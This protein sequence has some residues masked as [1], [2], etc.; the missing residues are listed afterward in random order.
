[1]TRPHD[2]WAEVYDLAYEQEFGA[3]FGYLTEQTL[4]VVGSLVGPG[5]DVVD[6]G[7]GTGR[8][9]T[10]LA[11][12]GHRVVA[13]EPSASMLARLLD[14]PQG[15]PVQRVCCAMQD[16]SSPARFD[17][18]LCVFTV[19]IYLLDEAA[20]DAAM[21]RAAACLRPGGRLLLDVPA[22]G[23]FRSRRASTEMLSREVTLEPAYG[24][25]YHYRER[26]IVH[27]GPLAGT[28]EDT[29]NIRHWP[30]SQVL[31]SAAGC[32]LKVQQELIHL[33]SGTGAEYWL[34]GRD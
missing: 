33:F 27:Q 5:A 18:A 8:L 10:P 17:L 4:E 29:F 32:G 15:P 6:F 2:T 34:L 20:L 13:V 21:A 7:A 26:I 1:V 24:S 11:G 23:A 16:F 25:V 14:P 12:A 22:L 3:Y 28:Y 9:A 31:A 19:V 30:S